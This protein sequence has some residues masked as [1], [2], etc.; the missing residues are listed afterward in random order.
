MNNFK[1]DLNEQEV[2]LVLQA[3][4]EMPAKLSMTLLLKL[5]AQIQAQLKQDNIVNI[6]KPKE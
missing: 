6:K 1:L 4:A 2:N 3:L 5:Q